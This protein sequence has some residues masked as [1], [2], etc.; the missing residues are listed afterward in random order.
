VDQA[1][2]I[3]RTSG[4]SEEV[5]TTTTPLYAEA[6]R[7]ALAGD[8]V[9]TEEHLREAGGAYWD[10]Q[11]E[12]VRTV[13]GER[14]AFIDRQVSAQLPTLMS[15][16]FR[17]VLGS[18][19]AADWSRVTVPVLALFGALDAQVPAAPNEPALRNALEQAGNDDVTVVTFPDANHLFQAAET[20]GLEEY[21]RLP[22][23][24]SADVLPT[25]VDWVVQRA[26]VSEDGPSPAP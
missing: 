18:D 14:E 15:D 5:L 1:E 20:G 16:W 12:D 21:G 13:L 9:A 23:T 6:Y 2:M 11:S 22:D 17:S 7:A 3:G 19:P 8:A 10:A 24:F 4:T 25:L 26:G